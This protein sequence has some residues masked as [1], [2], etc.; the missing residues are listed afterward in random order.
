MNFISLFSFESNFQR[1]GFNGIANL[2]AMM[3]LLTVDSVHGMLDEIS[4]VMS[5]LSGY[6]SNP[7][8]QFLKYFLTL[9]FHSFSPICSNFLSVCFYTST[10]F[11]IYILVGKAEFKFWSLLEMKEMPFS[12]FFI[13]NQSRVYHPK[14]KKKSV[15]NFISPFLFKFNFVEKVVY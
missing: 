9:S 5:I 4:T 6:L 1:K 7:E 3:I 11:L 10:L 15:M 8:Y 13:T 12:F 2:V 14:K